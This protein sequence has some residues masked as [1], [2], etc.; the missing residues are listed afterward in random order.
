MGVYIATE[1]LGAESAEDA[2][3]SVCRVGAAARVSDILISGY[4]HVA[5]R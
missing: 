4:G 1:G 3:G 5:V 2:A